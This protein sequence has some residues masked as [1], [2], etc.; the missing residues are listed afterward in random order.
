[1]LFSLNTA[2][3]SRNRDGDEMHSATAAAVSYTGKTLGGALQMLPH[4][5]ALGFDGKAFMDTVVAN[6]QDMGVMRSGPVTGGQEASFASAPSSF[7]AI[8][9]SGPAV[10]L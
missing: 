4:I 5:E 7:S 3:N 10:Q 1:V 2:E 6:L 9:N 8:Q